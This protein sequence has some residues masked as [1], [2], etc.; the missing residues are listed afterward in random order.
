M[1]Q[2]LEVEDRIA[3]E[4]ARFY[5]RLS[6]DYDVMTGLEKRF[7]H[8]R[9]FFNL[10]VQK[11][12][13]QTALDV[14]AGTGFHSLLLAQLGVEVTA[15]DISQKMLDRVRQHAKEMHLEVRTVRSTFQELSDRL[16]GTYDAVLCMGNSLPH[17]LTSQ[18]LRQAL[19]NFNEILNPEGVLFLQQLNYDRILAQREPIQ[20]V[21]EVG[22][23][24]FI[25]FYEYHTQ[26][27]MFNILKLKRVEGKIT[28]ELDSV[29]LRPIV[30]KEMENVLREAAFTHI[31]AHGSIA[32]DDFEEERSKDL[33]VLARKAVTKN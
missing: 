25:R 30:K 12:D 7:V 28:H 6:E 18:D 2:T 8:E 14:G 16:R 11:F 15:V 24:T 27:V 20:S 19:R 22:T 32:L 17:L 21:K 4:T 1:P 10:F 31:Q 3:E 23:T 33:V 13:V 26:S 5:D 29:R 9:P